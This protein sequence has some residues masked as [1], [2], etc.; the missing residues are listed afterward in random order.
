MSRAHPARVPEA[1]AAALMSLVLLLLPSCNP[2][3]PLELLDCSFRV[4][5]TEDFSVAGIV[6]DELEELTPGQIADFMS[7]WLSGSCP[8]S[9]TLDIGVT[10]PNDGSGGT[11]SFPATL[12]SFE[13]DLYLDTDS[14][15]GF[16]TTLVVSGSLAEPWTIPGDG[17]THVLAI[18]IG[19]DAFDLASILEPME[20]IDL[21]LAIGGIESDLR[22]ADHLGRLLL[23]ADVAVDTPIGPL[24][25][26]GSLWIGLDWVD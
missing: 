24:S 2:M 15:S 16:D 20:F 13:W 14:G 6:L 12:S 19:F 9:F 10:N 18:G 1:V 8:V 4:E 7:Y 22:D 26:P 5:G 23:R 25:Y 3:D 11:G 17:E 21:A